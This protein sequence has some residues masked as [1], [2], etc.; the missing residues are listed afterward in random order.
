MNDVYKNIE[1]YNRNKERKILIVFEDMIPDML[2]NEKP[3]PII[4]ELFIRGRKLNISLVFITQSYFVVLKNIILISTHYIV[5]KILNE[6]ELQK[7][8]F[9]HSSDIGFQVFMNL[10]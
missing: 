1:E 5:M 4:I 6:T 9:N 10:Y 3:N 2:S 8:A 7:I